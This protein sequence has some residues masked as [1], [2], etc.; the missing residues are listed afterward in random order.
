MS[1]SSTRHR[2]AL[3]IAFLGVAVSGVILY[4]EL[5]LANVPG[6]SAFC[7]LGGVVNC[8]LVL[9]SRYGT[10][11]GVPLG[12]WALVTFVVGALAAIPGAFLGITAGTADLL[13]I[14]LASGSLGFSV[15]LAVVMAVVLRHVCL[16]C[17]SLDVVVAAWFV[18]VLPLTR[19]FAA[20]TAVGWLQRRTVAHATAVA[21][22]VTAIASGALS[23]A[24][25]PP[26]I[27]TAA[28]I[29]SF[30]AAGAVP[31]RSR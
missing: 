16:L 23:A 19:N 22:V 3:A 25:T 27:A 20:S 18:T 12:V 11:L 28:E 10:F 6:H 13:L 4:E 2:V 26:A 21:A 9:S 17:L 8:D 15:V 30:A 24:Y 1:S 7:T 5:Q 29:D 14:A 31:R